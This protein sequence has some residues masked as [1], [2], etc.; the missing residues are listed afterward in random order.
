MI[1]TIL[2]FFFLSSAG[3]SYG[4]LDLNVVASGGGIDS[5]QQLS[6]EWT[7]GEISIA[8]LSSESIM[9]TEGFHQPILIVSDF[10]ESTVTNTSLINRGYQINVSPNPVNSF[11]N[12]QMESADD[13]EVMV[14]LFS[15]DGRPV[16]K[17]FKKEAN[18]SFRMNL[19]D[20]TPGLYLLRFTNSEGQLLRTFKLSKNN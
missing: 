14:N 11:I 8:T 3:W 16:A 9:I 13:S 1:K 20:L 12:V 15:I 7:L 2:I 17:E 18:D 4:Q 19:A 10:E 6:L 5:T